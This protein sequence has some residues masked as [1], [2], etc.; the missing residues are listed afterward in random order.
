[1]RELVSLGRF[2]YSQGKLTADDERKIHAALEYLSLH[3]IENDYIDELSGG[4]KQRAFLA[5]VVAQDTDY[6]LL[7]EP[8]NNLDMKYAVQI[9]RTLRRLCDELQ[10]TIVLVIHDINFASVYSDY[11][12]ALKDTRLAYFGKTNTIIDPDILRDVFDM[13]F[14]ISEL[15]GKK[16]C[17]YYN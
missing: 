16:I 12:A 8:V 4:Q 11:I 13:D 2:P 7:D 14:K 10:K 3:D 6:I 9:M 17:N 5:M 1:M 15:N